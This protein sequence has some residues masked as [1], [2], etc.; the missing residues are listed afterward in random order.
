MIAKVYWYITARVLSIITIQR[1]SNYWD[2]PRH[3][4]TCLSPALSYTHLK[5]M[6]KRDL[7]LKQRTE[8]N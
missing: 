5:F 1:G 3:T 4:V 6:K 8:S 7:S 2:L